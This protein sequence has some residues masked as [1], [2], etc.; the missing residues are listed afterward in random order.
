ADWVLKTHQ[1]QG[2]GNRGPGGQRANSLRF[3]PFRQRPPAGHV[4]PGPNLDA[5]GSTCWTIQGFLTVR[6]AKPQVIPARFIGASLRSAPS[7]PTRSPDQTD[8]GSSTCAADEPRD[9]LA[10]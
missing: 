5:H 1:G 3:A 4:R 2:L 10:P 6:T 8:E 9:R 7:S